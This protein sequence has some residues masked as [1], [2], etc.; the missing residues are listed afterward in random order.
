MHIPVACQP[1]TE[2]GGVSSRIFPV[3]TK[4][5]QVLPSKTKMGL[6]QVLVSAAPYMFVGIDFYV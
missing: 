1:V 4:S 6:F 3:H 5:D 2:I